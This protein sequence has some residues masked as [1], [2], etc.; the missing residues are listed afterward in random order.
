M[1]YGLIKSVFI[2]AGGSGY[3]VS[4]ASRTT[5]C[6][7][8]TGAFAQ[9]VGVMNITNLRS[10][11]AQHLTMMKLTEPGRKPSEKNRK[12]SLMVSLGRTDG[13][14]ALLGFT[15]QARG[16]GPQTYPRWGSEVEDRD[17]AREA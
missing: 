9:Y 17:P 8:R 14:E 15:N 7:H 10:I 13:W 3:I 11:P 16:Q 6:T 1:K 12:P 2:S 4:F 5:I